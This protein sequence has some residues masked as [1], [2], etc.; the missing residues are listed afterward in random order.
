MVECNF[1]EHLKKV[2]FQWL[3]ELKKAVDKEFQDRINKN[4]KKL[5]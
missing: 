3:S 4:Y 1:E 5:D 2:D